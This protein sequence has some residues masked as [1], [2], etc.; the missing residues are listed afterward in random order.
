MRSEQVTPSTVKLLRLVAG[1]KPVRPCRR[2]SK[3]VRL[4][5]LNA[6]VLGSLL[7][8]GGASVAVGHSPMKKLPN[9]IGGCCSSVRCA[10]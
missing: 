1:R 2:C 10:V 7:G 3:S 4:A 9:H 5:R 6:W 8:R